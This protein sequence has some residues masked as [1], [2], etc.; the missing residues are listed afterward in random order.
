M[1]IGLVTCATGRPE[2]QAGTVV[3][4]IRSTLAVFKAMVTY[5]YMYNYGVL[6]IPYSPE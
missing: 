5:K 1:Y 3:N 2:L 4:N 6:L